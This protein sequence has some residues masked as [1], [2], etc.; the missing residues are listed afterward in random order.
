[1]LDQGPIATGPSAIHNSQRRDAAAFLHWSARLRAATSYRG[2][3]KGGTTMKAGIFQALLMLG[4]ASL[5]TPAAGQTP[6][7]DVTA[8]M[9]GEL[10]TQVLEGCNSELTQYCAEVTPGEGRLLGCLYAYQD[11]LSGQC[12]L[13]LYDAAARLERAIGA[14]TYVASECRSE[15]ETHCADVEVG[16]GRVAQCLK[17][18]AAELSP[19]CDQA[20]TDVGAQ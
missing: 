11:K 20:L 4:A 10:A 6:A 14:I 16:E 13:A 19:G 9:Q 12:E 18:H 7:Q 1:M 8:A 5:V 3:T 15:L 2:D 17:D